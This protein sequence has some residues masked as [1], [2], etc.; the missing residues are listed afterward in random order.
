MAHRLLVHITVV[1]AVVAS[2]L[3]EPAQPAGSTAGEAFAVEQTAKPNIVVILTDDMVTRELAAMPLTRQLIAQ[4]GVT[5]ANSFAPMPLCCPSRVSMLTGQYAHNH[6]VLGNG[7]T[8]C[9]HPEGGFAG[10]TTDGNTLATWLHG[11][12][13]QTVWIGKYL[14]GYG[15]PES[16]A[17]KPPGWDGWHGTVGGSYRKFQAF[18]QGKL[19]DYRDTHQTTWTSRGGVDVIKKRIPRAAPLFLFMSYLAPHN[20]GP[21]DTDDPTELG[22]GTPSPAPADRN[23]SRGVALPMSRPSTRTTY[24]ISPSG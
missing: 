12:G 3:V 15:A 14:N 4:R 23:D 21:V 9:C 5:F 22:I 20:G 18:E 1:A 6:G 8:D 13:Y 11:A 7:P 24:A 19:V 16:P 17:R 2:V 10:F